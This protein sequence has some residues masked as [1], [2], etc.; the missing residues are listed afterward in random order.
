MISFFASRID[1][2][3]IARGLDLFAAGPISCSVLQYTERLHAENGSE[4]NGHH[5]FHFCSNS[6][7]HLFI[8]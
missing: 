5:P 1:I 4:R 3:S 7:Q 2:Y 8:S 6:V